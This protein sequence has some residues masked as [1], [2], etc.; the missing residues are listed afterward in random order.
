MA[1]EARELAGAGELMRIARMR[2]K[3]RLSQTAMG[4]KIGLTKDQLGR[5]E[6]GQV[7]AGADQFLAVIRETGQRDLIDEWMRNNDISVLSQDALLAGQMSL[8]DLFIVAA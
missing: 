8:D 2:M 4:K 6:R 1:V 7:P 5:I 3:P